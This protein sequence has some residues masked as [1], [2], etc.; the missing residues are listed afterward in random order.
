MTSLV[1]RSFDQAALDAAYD[2]RGAVPD[3]M[4]WRASWADRSQ[5]VYATYR[6]DRDVAYGA[7][8][9]QRYDFLHCGQP[10]APTFAYIHGGYWHLNDKEPHAFIGEAL[11]AS[12][13]NLVLIEYTLAP[14][15]TMDAIVGEIRA[16]V[17]HIVANLRERF[18]ASDRLVVGGHS[19]GGHL[20]AMAMEEPG[21]SGA[22][23]ISGLYD[24]E[25]IRLHGM[26]KT[27]GMSMD[28]A[29][30]NSPMLRTP[31]AIPAIV[32]VGGAEL[33]ELQRQSREYAGYLQG[34]QLPARLVVLPGENHFSILE[35]LARLDGALAAT[36]REL[37]K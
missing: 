2:N 12:G 1:Y 36:V 7:L 33:A 22:L 5:A 24:L 32:T 27:L 19:A 20:T 35:S 3:H 18:G 31:R 15:T 6:C 34:K 10:N 4:R 28:D 14:H 25:P 16:C 37:S 21:V 11:L 29:R 23:L 13:I 8:A 17:R 9:R 30:R 26:N